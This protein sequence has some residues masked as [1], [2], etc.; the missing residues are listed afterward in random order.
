MSHERD[1]RKDPA[2]TQEFLAQ[3]LGTRPFHSQCGRQ[4]P[5]RGGNDFLHSRQTVTILNKSKL[6]A[7]SCDCYRCGRGSKNRWQSE[8]PERQ[9]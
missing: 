8:T 9:T 4:H 2:F 6:E 7:A 5:G 1:C 3:M